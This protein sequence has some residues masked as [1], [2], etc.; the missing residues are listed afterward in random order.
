MGGILSMKHQH[1][2][3]QT[4]STLQH[5]RHAHVYLIHNINVEKKHDW[6]DSNEFT[7]FILLKLTERF[8]NG[9]N[10]ARSYGREITVL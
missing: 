6:L 3:M 7:Q 2:T 10:F 1:E 8:A 5:V 4:R 9:K